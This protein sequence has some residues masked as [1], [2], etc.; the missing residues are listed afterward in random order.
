MSELVILDPRSVQHEARGSVVASWGDFTGL[1][2][3]VIDNTKPNFDKVAAG[4]T[5]TLQERYGVAEVESSRKRT[6]TAPAADD[7][8]ERFAASKDLVLTGSGD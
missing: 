1:R 5:D 2:V 3:G 6:A 8:Y 7:V 4:L